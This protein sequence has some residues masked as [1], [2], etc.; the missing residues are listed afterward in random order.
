MPM[1]RIKTLRPCRKLRTIRRRPAGERKL[2]GEALKDAQQSAN[3]AWQKV[4]DAVADKLRSGSAANLQTAVNGV[5]AQFAGDLKFQQAVDKA[6]G[7]VKAV[8]DAVGRV[9]G[10]KSALGNSS[11]RAA[12]GA[13]NLQQNLNSAQTA[14]NAAVGHEIDS[15]AGPN[16]DEGAVA[17]AGQKIMAQYAGDPAGQQ[18][19]KEATAA[20]LLQGVTPNPQNPEAALRSLNGVYSGAPQGFKDA[21]LNDPKA[22]AIVGDAVNW[23]NDPL[24]HPN[25]MAQQSPM[26]AQ[27]SLSNA[28]MR[29]D[30]L[31]QGL[32]ANLA[33]RVASQAMPAYIQFH[34][35]MS[36]YMPFGTEGLISMMKVGG[37]IAGTPEGDRAIAGFASMGGWGALSEG[38]VYQSLSE[39]TNPA[40]A[41]AVVKQTLAAGNTELAGHYQN[42]IGVGIQ[43]FAQGKLTD[44]V[45]K[46]A[47]HNAEL[48]WLIKNDGSLMSPQQLNKAVEAYK[49]SHPGWNQEETQ[50]VNQ[51]TA[52]GSALLNMM[53]QYNK[54]VDPNSNSDARKAID[55]TLST[56]GKNQAAGFA[57]D[58]AL[59]S[60]PALAEPQNAYGLADLF[61]FSKAGTVFRRFG[62]EFASM[63]FRSKLQSILSA[64]PRDPNAAQEFMRQNVANIPDD[65]VFKY[66]FGVT[67]AEAKAF[68]KAINGMN[69]TPQSTAAEVEAELAKVSREVSSDGNLSKTFNAETEAGTALR[70]LAMGVAFLSLGNSFEKVYHGGVGDAQNDLKLVLDAG[71]ATQRTLDFARSL[72]MVEDASKLGQFGGAWKW[73]V[74]GG[75]ASAGDI[76]SAVSVGFDL[77]TAVRDFAGGDVPN[78][79]TYSGL[80]VGGALS[81]APA[82][83]FSAWFGPIG[84]GVSAAVIGGKWLWDSNENAHQYEGSS[85]Q[86]LQAGGFGH[87][88]ANRLNK[89]DG[90]FSGA[91]GASE[92]EFL[93]RYAQL[94]N[95]TPQQ[96]QDWVN[97]LSDAQLN[98]LS[99]VLMRLAEACHG[100]VN[101]FTNGPV[102]R[103]GPHG[104]NEDW[105]TVTE[106]RGMLLA[107]GINP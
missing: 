66:V 9:E 102:H 58:T 99:Q 98:N 100:D 59:Q 83:G 48:S 54:A 85:A 5:R 11:A 7:P 104:R 74:N 84:V 42:S 23:A 62:K 70:F 55:Q 106:F 101:Q 18:A 4:Q 79:L 36:G 21:I 50:L 2:A 16:A 49:Q 14:L 17:R 43:A 44:D 92:T 105:N 31:T 77:V 39:G 69:I 61:Q 56:I 57:I 47:G 96:L 29:A 1:V 19:V 71:Q 53:S 88:A 41:M 97:R 25:P 78:G 51:V 73:T 52:D 34:K 68:N 3:S 32:D 35:G 89:R 28:I 46:L 76:L 63:V 87:D 67:D 30:K 38:A 22:Q 12:I 81:M 86:F 91:T 107:A 95:K 27:G 8:D 103:F 90:I 13:G 6:Y 75:A 15:M 60:N 37:R 20:R 26:F 64:A 82:F 33:A 94:T 72:G 24:T 40:Y 10:A 45:N 65:P 93:N 80:V